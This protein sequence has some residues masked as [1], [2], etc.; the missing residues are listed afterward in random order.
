MRATLKFKLSFATTVVA[1][2]AGLLAGW[3]Q[4]ERMSQDYL[5]LIERQQ[6]T[7]TDATANALAEK[8]DMQLRVL[9]R[10]AESLGTAD[11]NDRSVVQ[12]P[13]AAAA[14]LFSTV[15]LADLEGRVSASRRDGSRPP[16]DISDR[17]Y[18]RIA[19]DAG[20]AN[21]SP[22][23]VSRL[24][25]RPVVLMA[26]PV[27]GLD[28]RVRAVLVGS[29][30]LENPNA[31]GALGRAK[32]G[33]SGHFVVATR[34]A[35]PVY[36]V[37]PDKE[38]VLKPVAAIESVRG[39]QSLAAD[40]PAA[41]IV[42][43]RYLR[44]VNWELRTVLPAAEAMRPLQ[45]AHADL[46]RETLTLAFAFA[47][48]V[49]GATWWM[50]RPLGT[51]DRI[52]RSLRQGAPL[53][54]NAVVTSDDEIGDVTREFVGLMQQLRAS[55]AELEAVHDASPIG[56]FRTDAGGRLL[57][58]NHGYLRICGVDRHQT[59]S[60]GWPA[61]LAEVDEAAEVRQ[62]WIEA[63]ASGQPY[64]GTHRLLRPADGQA[65]TVSVHGAPVRVGGVLG[66][67]VGTVEDVTEQR[68][69][70]AALQQSEAR[71]RSILTHAPDAFISIDA[72]GRIT[73][74][75]R[76]AETTFGWTAAE[77][78]GR[79]LGELMVPPS[80]RQAHRRGLLHFAHTGQGAVVNQRLEV[81]ALHRDG[82]EIPV[83][84]SVASVRQGGD[85]VAH[86]FLHDITERKTVQQLL[87]DKEKRLRAITDNLPVLIG[88]ISRDRRYTFTNETY[89][90][91][92]GLAPESMIGR[93]VEELL[94]PQLYAQ[95]RE[96][97]DRALRGER[98]S[99]EG[100]TVLAGVTRQL[101][102]DYV[103]DIDANGQ[104]AGIYTLSS[105]I[106]ALK[107]VQA[108]LDQLARSDS[109][110]GLPNRYEFERKLQEA[111][112]R[113]RRSG[114]T[115]ALMYLDIDKFKS[116]NDSLG[117]AAGDAVLKEF[118]LR[119]KRSVRGTDT[120][121]RLSGDEFV[122]ILEGLRNRD[123]AQFVARKIVLA[124]R[125][126]FKVGLQ[127]LKVTTSIG[128]ACDADG[129]T[130]MA[131][132]LASADRALYAAKGAGRDGFHLNA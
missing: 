97:L 32:V 34:G 53:P 8:L 42:T 100:E 79:D 112:A 115:L 72:E 103:P 33:E 102:T 96:P 27:I 73:D 85:W 38:R 107:E 5:Q 9:Q 99:F 43:R 77:A 106:T 58:A 35:D 30:D 25:G 116:I 60:E 13:L 105:D 93:K 50:L 48:L 12:P 122:I 127:A 118:A 15:Y 39:L 18:F 66:G 65:V 51:L 26:A 129:H 49:W 40:D 6:E 67:F 120:V 44:Q 3:L 94:G 36:V 86:A 64:Q 101:H 119:L 128:I 132:L 108:R 45:H 28:G 23:L 24:S 2:L 69:M 84:L 75:N 22:P 130:G 113:C 62:R 95:R 10:A 131:E 98:V 59:G 81:N 41:A 68:A 37:H 80:Q 124:V 90:D 82:R 20:E 54:A 7:L 14:T 91:W 71:V 52:I 117:H 109:L 21:I 70:Q 47:L 83:E 74:W 4:R 19:R 104:V 31:I 56:M 63:I 16:I 111:Q 88:Y 125:K 123:E 87:A 57:Y 92:T 89:R 76:R 110:T 17:D 121:A 46:L 126:D 11:L 61:L 29:L 78:I 1:V 114:Q 55:T